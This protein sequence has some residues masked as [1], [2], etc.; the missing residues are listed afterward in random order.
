[1]NRFDYDRFNGFAK[2]S[3]DDFLFSDLWNHDIFNESDMHSAAY[4][5]IREYFSKHGRDNVYVRCEPVL[6]GMKPDI[7]VYERGKPIYVLEFKCFTKLDHINEDAVY[8][9]LDKLAKAVNKFSSIR[10]GF[11]HMIYDADKAYTFSDSRLR[12]GGYS[13]MS[14]TSINARRQENNDRRRVR[15]D[16]WRSEF[17]RLQK[18][19]RKLA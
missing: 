16:E 7:V 10:W 17:D 12:R 14:F 15:Y 4:Y 18:L 8:R 11:F 9:D 2:K 13:K 6:D 3:L 5:Y 19:H 1:M